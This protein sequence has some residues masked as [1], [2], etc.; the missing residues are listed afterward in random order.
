MK[1][2]IRLPFEDFQ[3]SF[4]AGHRFMI[5]GLRLSDPPFRAM[6][7]QFSKRRRRRRA[8]DGPRLA[9]LEIDADAARAHARR[10]ESDP[11]VVE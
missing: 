5:G 7:F 11:A 3:F 2:E 4:T 10:E 9:L 1:Y 8:S 6:A